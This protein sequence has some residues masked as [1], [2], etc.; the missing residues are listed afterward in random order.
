M[1]RG[2]SCLRF[3]RSTEGVIFV[4]SLRNLSY[5][6]RVSNLH[7][8]GNKKAKRACLVSVSI[9]S[10]SR[11][12]K[13]LPPISETRERHCNITPRSVSSSSSNNSSRNSDADNDGDNRGGERKALRMLHSA[14]TACSLT[15]ATHRWVEGEGEHLLPSSFP[16]PT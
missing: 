14:P 4:V 2:S 16:L 12:G 6:R 9:R 13:K 7:E 5:D 11:F 8:Y 3:S 1:E 15:H 10:R